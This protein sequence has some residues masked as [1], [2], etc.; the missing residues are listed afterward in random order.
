MENGERQQILDKL[1][2]FDIVFFFL[3]VLRRFH[4]QKEIIKFQF[5]HESRAGIATGKIYVA[6]NSLVLRADDY[7]IAK[8]VAFL[9]PSKLLRSYLMLRYQQFSVTDCIVVKQPG[10]FANFH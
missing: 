9:C 8:T 10:I 5:A 4:V 3:F 2:A 1:K 6:V 7:I